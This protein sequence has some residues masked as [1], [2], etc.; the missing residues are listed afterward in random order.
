VL[1]YRGDAKAALGKYEGA[2]ED[3]RRSGTLFAEVNE[4]LALYALDRWVEAA[5]IARM[6]VA[7]RP[8]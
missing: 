4:A 5:R 6:V 8:G 3:F 2:L 1:T 7:K